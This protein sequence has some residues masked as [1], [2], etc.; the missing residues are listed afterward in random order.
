MMN[1]F[2]ALRK[3]R[4]YTLKDLAVLT[5]LSISF[6]SDLERG[7]SNP[8]VQ[9][10]QLLAKTYSVTLNTL[11]LPEREQPAEPINEQAL[12][13]EIGR[14]VKHEREQLGFTQGDLIETMARDV[15]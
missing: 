15:G 10:L 5:G 7:R 1:P 9:T 11:V 2:Q 4:N 6:L 3:S 13:G 14:R 8:S 12:Y